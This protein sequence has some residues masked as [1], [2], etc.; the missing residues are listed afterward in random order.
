MGPLR[1]GKIGTLP[2]SQ[3]RDPS[4]LANLG[5]FRIGTLPDWQKIRT[6]RIGKI[7]TLPDW[8]P[9]GLAKSAFS[10]GL[11]ISPETLTVTFSESIMLYKLTRKAVTRP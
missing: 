2:D 11:K 6:F 3:K 1:I 8:N 7:G 10:G 4:G 5:P 9:S